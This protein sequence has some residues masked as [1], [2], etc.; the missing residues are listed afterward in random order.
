MNLRVIIIN[1]Y[2]KLTI[3]TYYSALKMSFRKVFDCFNWN[4]TSQSIYSKTGK[5][6][7]QAIN[8]SGNCTLEDFMALVSPAAEKYL[9]EMAQL[10]HQLTTTRFGKV[11]Q[12]YI[13]MYLSNECQNICTYC[14]F[15]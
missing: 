14:G 4:D 8:N 9:E 6:V 12:M 10:S 3:Q 1:I 11:M 13:P 2:L 5:D 15:S 7:L